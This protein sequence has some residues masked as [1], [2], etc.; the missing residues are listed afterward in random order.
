MLAAMWIS[1]HSTSGAGQPGQRIVTDRDQ[2][3]PRD[4]KRLGDHVVTRGRGGSTPRIGANL[5]AA[6]V[7]GV[8]SLGSEPAQRSGAKSPDATTNWLP[9]GRRLGSLD[10]AAA[11][12]RR[13]SCDQ[14]AVSHEMALRP[15]LSVRWA[16]Q[17]PD[18]SRRKKE[19]QRRVSD[20]VFRRRPRVG[21]ALCVFRWSS[22]P[23]ETHTG[24]CGRRVRRRGR[25]RWLRC[26]GG[27]AAHGRYRTRS[28]QSR[29]RGARSAAPRRWT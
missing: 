28:R 15:L 10:E 4:Q 20:S 11:L 3:P 13:R 1:D 9:R 17:I 8:G 26:R 25:G 14:A 12:R 7:T 19:R 16:G 5:P 29:R 23:V 21:G 27:S 2:P 6:A 18:E 24:S 22:S